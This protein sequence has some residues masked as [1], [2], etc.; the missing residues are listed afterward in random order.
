VRIILALFA[1][2]AGASIF[3]CAGSGPDAEP[4][5]VHVLT[6]D[7]HVGPVMERYIDRGIDQA[8]DADAE[9][10]VI[11][12]DTPGG[13][14]SSMDDIIQRILSSK[15]PIVL[16]V[17]PSGGQAAS[18]GTYI[19][20]ASQVIVMSP[21]TT[22]GAATPISGSGEDLN[23]D[24]R[25][26]LVNSSVAKIREYAELRGRNGDWAEDAVRTGAS[27][28]AFEA[29]D[30]N[31]ADYVADD[32]PE[33]L[34]LIDGLEVGLP[35]SETTVLETADAQLAYN[36]TNFIEDILD[37][38]ADP[39][40]AFLLLSLGSLA[41]F[42]EIIH[43]G[44]IFPGTFGVIALLLGFFALSVLPFNWAG[45]AL[46]MFAFFLF[47]LELFVTSGGVLGIG[48]AVS[49]VLGGM[50]LTSGNPP[51][52]QVDKW[53]IIAVTVPLAGMVLFVL[54]NVVRI[55]KQPARMG[56]ETIVGK[57]AVARSALAPSGMV[58]MDGEYWSAESEGEPIEPGDKVI[59][60][61]VRGLR[62]K[63][64]RDN[65]EGA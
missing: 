53:V 46:I 6:T 18:A 31:I 16:Y 28:S 21:G 51:E 49:L 52:F 38:L 20:Y 63:V 34:R 26:K 56:I 15:V 27:A 14:L 1:V 59:V 7:S 43:P 50:L 33:L 13:L 64:R 57:S 29:V 19:A 11:R 65:P 8:E 5:A 61:E 3:A 39:N 4:G 41:L 12:M 35:N 45:V 60:I 17:W 30:L 42:I 58:S 32:L 25:N 40:I 22:I 47:G 23:E 9:A 54:V 37:I 55:R 36:D 62:L 2:L 48:G 24:L 44:A 10:V